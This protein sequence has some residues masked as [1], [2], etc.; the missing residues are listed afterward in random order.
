M[1]RAAGIAGVV[2]LGLVMAGPSLAQHAD[3]GAPKSSAK[4]TKPRANHQ[5]A[6]RAAATAQMDP[7][8]YT[9]EPRSSVPRR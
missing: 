5:L 9:G 1:T 3:H 8:H 2:V 7:R 6:A 4:L